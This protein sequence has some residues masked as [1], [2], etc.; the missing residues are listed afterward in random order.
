MMTTIFDK[1]GESSDKSDHEIPAP[2]CSTCHR[3][4]DCVRLSSA[5][6]FLKREQPLVYEKWKTVPLTVPKLKKANTYKSRVGHR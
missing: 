3:M 5:F 1:I 4:Q 6:F 2:W